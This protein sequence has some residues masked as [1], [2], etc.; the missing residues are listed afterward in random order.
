M[1][2]RIPCGDL[3]KERPRIFTQ[4]VNEDAIAGN[5][6]QLQGIINVS[7]I[8]DEPSGGVHANVNICSYSPCRGP[9][10]QPRRRAS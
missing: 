10:N 2:S 6:Q 7:K 3:G 5:P 4:R 8:E 1:D 9:S